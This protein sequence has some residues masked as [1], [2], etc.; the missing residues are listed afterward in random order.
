ML[1]LLAVL[2]LALGCA[3]QPRPTQPNVPAPAGKANEAFGF[4]FRIHLTEEVRDRL[5]WSYIWAIRFA[6]LRWEQIVYSGH[7]TEFFV[8]MSKARG[9]VLSHDRYE[10]EVEYPRSYLGWTDI[11][12][13]VTI[14]DEIEEIDDDGDGL[15]TF[16]RTVYFLDGN[17]DMYPIVYLTIP[18]YVIYYLK[19]GDY[20][21]DQFFQACVHELGHALGFN[22]ANL[23]RNLLERVAGEWEYK[24]EKGKEAFNRITRKTGNIPMFDSGHFDGFHTKW[25][26][27]FDVMF[28]GFLGSPV[29]EDKL[30]SEV[31]VGVLEDLGWWVRY[32]QADNTLL[33]WKEDPRNPNYAAKPVAG[34]RF[35]CTPPR[36]GKVTILD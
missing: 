34:G 28:Q 25:K 26:K 3:D 21:Y 8:D 6:A 22:S 13:V 33:N 11:E 32:S 14:D 30:I 23:E 24:G 5:D 27:Y 1:R 20:S 10:L 18:H 31:S 36:Q 9:F 17:D 19:S 4:D 7:Q 12:I 35:H 2:V 15:I 29:P 16:A